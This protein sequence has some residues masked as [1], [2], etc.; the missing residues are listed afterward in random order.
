MLSFP[1]SLFTFVFFSPLL[2][3]LFC[4]SAL[5]FDAVLLCIGSIVGFSVGIGSDFDGIN[6]TPEGLEDASKYPALVRCFLSFIRNLR[7]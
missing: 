6:S 2:L 4:S 3:L 5:L 7:L 1:S